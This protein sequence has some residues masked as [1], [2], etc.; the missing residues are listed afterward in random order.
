MAMIWRGPMVQSAIDQLLFQ[1][2]W[3]ETDVLVMDL[4]PGMREREREREGGRERER[5]GKRE[6]E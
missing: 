6:R 3:G 1:V 2:E 4:P 5:E